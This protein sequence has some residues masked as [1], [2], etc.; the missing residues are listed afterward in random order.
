MIN[1]DGTFFYKT[2]GATHTHTIDVRDSLVK[3][4]IEAAKKSA[5]ESD[6]KTRELYSDAMAGLAEEVVTQMPSANSFGKIMRN[7][8]KHDHPKA[9]NNLSELKLPPI[10]TK[11]DEEFV[12]YDSGPH[13]TDRIIIFATHQGM[14]FLA[15]CSTLH[16]DGTVSSGPVLFDQIYVIHGKF[17]TYSEFVFFLKQCFKSCMT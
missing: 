17:C 6:K 15:Q 10:K 3:G 9:P 7:Q 8:R 1:Q 4:R 11:A 5:K 12:M 14:D 13:P 2:N 16:M